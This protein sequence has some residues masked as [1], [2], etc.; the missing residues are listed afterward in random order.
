MKIKKKK[1]EPIPLK[2]NVDDIAPEYTIAVKNRFSTLIQIAEEMEPE[3]LAS[4][5]R[6]IL[7]DEGKKHLK[8]RPKKSKKWISEET[9]EKVQERKQLKKIKN[10]EEGEA[11]Y[12]ILNK[13]VKRL[14]K[15]DK[16]QYI[17]DKCEKI[18]KL[19]SQN[20]SREMYQEIKSL[21]NKR[22]ARTAT[23]KD[24][25]GKTL[26]EDKEIANRWVEY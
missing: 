20:K 14:L 18:E 2:L 17:K 22:S 6:D 11:N 4:E 8:K 12:K 25:N 21:T 24:K 10:T 19:K 9:L 1:K 5:I 13:E 16:K 7:K 23:I 15:R 26:I 3:I